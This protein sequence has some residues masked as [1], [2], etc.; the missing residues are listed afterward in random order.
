LR[1]DRRD[2]YCTSYQK[3][4]RYNNKK[5][6]K[7]QLDVTCYNCREP[8]HYVTSCPKPKEHKERR[9]EAKIQAVQQ[10]N[11]DASHSLS[12][13][14]STWTGS[15]EPIAYDTSLELLN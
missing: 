11:T 6:K 15:K 14:P 3:D 2:R 8:G 10:Y 1:R 13:T 12:L 5:P 4:E 7:G 9:L